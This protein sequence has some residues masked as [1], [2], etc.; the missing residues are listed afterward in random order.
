[1]EIWREGVEKQEEA[2]HMVSLSKLIECLFSARQFCAVLGTVMHKT[3]VV[4]DSWR[5]QHYLKHRGYIQI[6]FKERFLYYPKVNVEKFLQR[7][8][9]GQQALGRR[10]DITQE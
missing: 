9:K 2:K 1:M 10:P 6:T 3:D 4:S 7:F 5:R 8:F